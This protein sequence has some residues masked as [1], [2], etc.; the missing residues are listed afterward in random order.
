MFPGCGVANH[1]T[2]KYP[3]RKKSGVVPSPGSLFPPGNPVKPVLF[4]A[5]KLGVSQPTVDLKSPPLS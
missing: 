4:V 3:A 5:P 1:H 2:P